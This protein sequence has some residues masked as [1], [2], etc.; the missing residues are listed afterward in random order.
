MDNVKIKL[1]SGIEFHAT[2]NG[3][4]YITNE[5]ITEEM[6]DDVNL[7]GMEID[8]V[9]LDNMT[10]CNYWTAEDGIHIIFRQYTTEELERQELNA[11]L[12]YIAMMEDIEL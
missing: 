9:V 8:G 5:E 4:N 10:C 1:G 6:L 7:I 2:L 12:E 11:K 3:N